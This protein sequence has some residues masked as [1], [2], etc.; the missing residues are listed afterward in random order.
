MG[1]ARMGWAEPV[2]G[3][4]EVFVHVHAMAWV[5]GMV[6]GVLG[7]CAYGVSWCFCFA[8]HPFPTVI[9]I[10]GH[11]GSSRCSGHMSFLFP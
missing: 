9:S 8:P 5:L 11:W 2:T 10:C 6:C 4:N 1:C 7:S 3:V